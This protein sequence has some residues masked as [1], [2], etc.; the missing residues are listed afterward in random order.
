MHN[1]FLIL[2]QPSSLL[3]SVNWDKLIMRPFEFAFHS[4]LLKRV[5]ECNQAQGLSDVML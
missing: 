2:N 5:L 3:C 4:K 1:P